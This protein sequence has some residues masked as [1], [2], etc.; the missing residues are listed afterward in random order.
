MNASVSVA[1]SQR[2]KSSAFQ[3]VSRILQ[4]GVTDEV[5]PGAV[6]LV[7]LNGRIVF[8]EAAG[9]KSYDSEKTAMQLDTVFDIASVSSI[10]STVTILML[11]SESRR[12][13]LDDKVTRYIQGFSV[14][15]KSAVSVRHL[16]N[17]TSGL[18]YWHP[19]YEE[20]L[21]ENSGARMGILTSKGARDYIIN[22]ISRMPL[23]YE[24]GTKQVYSDLNLILAG[25]LIEIVTGLSLDRATFHYV[26]HPLTL[27]STS[28][29]DISK[30]KRR[31]I[32]PVKD[33]IAPTENC[34][35]RKRVLCGEVHDDNAWA[36]GGVAGHSGIFSNA[37][38]LHSFAVELL[39]SYR[40]QSTFL[41]SDTVG[42]FWKG[43]GHGVE[44]GFR[45]GW[46]S[47]SRENNM[48]EAGLSSDAV[49]V[50]GFTGCSLW[51][52]PSLGVDIILMSN[53][54]HPS[55]SNKKIR[56]FRPLLHQAIIQAL[57]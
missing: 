5:F 24:P 41:S 9:Y 48:L 28:F 54:V 53:R 32:H 38:D 39:R 52:D 26:C 19:F 46:D 11:M 7:G 36:M 23:K 8:G 55:R 47:P 12:L 18:P 17:H 2:D 51:I 6:L 49:G 42:L 15:G 29:V 16:L 4:K 35:W 34:P 20:L 57:K 31:G 27:K 50:S 1:S 37:L 21:R 44:V 33:L 25:H 13:S 22:A 40:G 3:D 10:L 45:L 30:I 43:S 56:N 14:L